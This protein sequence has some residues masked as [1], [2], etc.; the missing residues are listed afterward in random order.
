MLQLLPLIVVS[1]H[2]RIIRIV[3]SILTHSFPMQP[4]STPESIRKPYG[5][6][7]FSGGRK[8]A[9][10]ERMRYYFE[11]LCFDTLILTWVKIVK[12]TLKISLLSSY[13]HPWTYSANCASFVQCQQ[14]KNWQNL[15]KVNSKD[16]RTTFVHFR[17]PLKAFRGLQKDWRFSNVCL[18][19]FE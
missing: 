9:L 7:L 1:Q 13:D 11:L 5:F 3:F 14:W 15:F 16:I 19:N 10:W 4:F 8:R 17:S 12:V 6:L 2:L 18:V